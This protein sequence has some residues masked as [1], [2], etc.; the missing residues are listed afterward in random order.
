MNC[1]RLSKQKKQTMGLDSLV[2]SHPP[3][4]FLFHWRPQRR[5]LLAFVVLDTIFLSTLR[6]LQ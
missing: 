2:P 4:Y 6:H 1:G 3:D 5:K